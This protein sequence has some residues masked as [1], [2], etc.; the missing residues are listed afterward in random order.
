MVLNATP[1]SPGGVEGGRETAQRTGPKFYLQLAFQKFLG[2]AQPT[3]PSRRL[4]RM[5]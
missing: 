2:D 1:N 3:P 5:K 4:G